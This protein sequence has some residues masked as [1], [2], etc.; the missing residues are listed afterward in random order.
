MGIR[1]LVVE[2]K[3]NHQ[4]DA[5]KCLKTKFKNVVVDIAT[6]YKNARDMLENATYDGVLSDVFF[7][8]MDEKGDIK[9]IASCLKDGKGFV[10]RKFTLETC[11]DLFKNELP[12][13]VLIGHY[14][15]NKNLPI[16]LITDT[17][18]H[19]K[20]TE[21]VN[22]WSKSKQVPLVDRDV[23]EESCEEEGLDYW[24]DNEDANQHVFCKKD[25]LKGF[26]VLLWMIS[27]KNRKIVDISTGGIQTEIPF[28]WYSS[29]LDCMKRKDWSGYSDQKES[30][31]SFIETAK[32]YL[33]HCP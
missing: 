31:E 2:D 8:N 26:F 15:L 23:N 22:G 32:S 19:G 21:P 5:K 16:V 20:K 17:Y 9:H 11:K 18:H 25:W 24:N 10:G 27:G 6:T 33:K 14:L 13:G 1:L 29:F 28:G 30:V 12:Y 3:S 4:K 7:P